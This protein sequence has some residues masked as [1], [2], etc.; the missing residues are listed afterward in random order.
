MVWMVQILRGNGSRMGFGG[1]NNFSTS[2][3]LV[4]NLGK[5]IRLV[6][7]I[8]GNT[9]QYIL[10]QHGQQISRMIGN[11]LGTWQFQLLMAILIM[12]AFKM[13]VN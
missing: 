3:L 4:L 10:K 6:T 13:G 8:T 11:L 12:A 5:G 7:T 1:R 9:H 2:N